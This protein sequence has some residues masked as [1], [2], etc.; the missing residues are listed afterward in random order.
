M[1]YALIVNTEDCVGGNTCEVACKQ[2]NNLPTGSRWIRVFPDSPRET[3]GKL[4]LRYIV[5][6]CIHCSQP[7]CKDACP[8]EAIIQ[9]D[10]GIVLI[11]EIRGGATLGFRI[12]LGPL[13]K[14]NFK[15]LGSLMVWPVSSLSIA[16]A[17]KP[18][19]A[20]NDID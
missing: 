10:D 17:I 3:D 9:R 13:K 7:I 1:E 4:Q 5:T 14:G 6:H 11:D 20:K 15:G 16:I 18:I 19:K 2:E 8:V 12:D